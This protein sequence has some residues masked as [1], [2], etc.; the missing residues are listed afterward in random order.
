MS[1]HSEIITNRKNNGLSLWGPLSFFAMPLCYVAAFVVFFVMMEIPHAA[2]L[3][4]KV[5]YMAEQKVLIHMG[6]II[7]YLIF[8]CLL[9]IAVQA[10]H[11]QMQSPSASELLNTASVFGLIWVFLMMCSA[12]ISV[13]GMEQLVKLY[14]K[15]SPYMDSFLFTYNMI[16]DALGG[17][18]ETIGGLWVLLIS[19]CGLRHGI[20]SKSLHVLGLLVGTCGVLTIILSIPEFKDAFGLTQIIWFIWMGLQLHKVAKR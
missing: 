5:A 13:V 15:S 3:V 1:N 12:L 20:F 8:G 17:G 10:L 6:N 4:E 14:N 19:L 9:L 7:G 16:V 18:I 2:P 11:K